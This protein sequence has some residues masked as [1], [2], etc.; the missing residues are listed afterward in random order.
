MHLLS[1]GGSVQS[2][3]EFWLVAGTAGSLVLGVLATVIPLRIGF[4][5]FQRLEF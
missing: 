3:L 5:A 1:F 2:W 4:G